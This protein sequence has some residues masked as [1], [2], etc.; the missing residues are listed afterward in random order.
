MAKKTPTINLSLVIVSYCN[1]PVLE[2][3]LDSFIKEIRSLRKKA[4][5]R[6]E[7]IVVDSLA[8]EKTRDVVKAKILKGSPVKYLPFEENTGFAKAV[9]AGIG[10]SKGKLILILNY[11]IIATS[12]SLGRMYTF[13]KSRP[14][15]GILG[16]QLLNFDGSHQPSSFHF[17]TPLIILLRRTILGKTKWGKKKLHDFIIDTSKSKKPV[18]IN[19]WLMG[20]SLMLRREN[21]DKI[22]MMDERYF[23]YFEDV[24]WCRRFIEKKYK[25]IY[26][27]SA[28]FFH[29][30]GKQSATRR[31]WEALF[32]R[33]TVIH[34]SS[35]VKYFWKFFWK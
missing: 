12:G 24:D 33:M 2:L 10:E 30:H 11:D 15:T 32:N 26:L 1:A 4:K 13:L 27:P 5:V 8:G 21:L 34:I 29:Y 16:P 31:S 20:S 6:S 28:K 3:C 25:V 7:I 22:G 17:Y 19:G 14:K 35:A 18:S 9:N 23:M